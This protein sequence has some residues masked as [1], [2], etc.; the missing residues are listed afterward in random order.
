MANDQTT[1]T[2]APLFTWRSAI[3]ES[4]LPPS[5]RH[6]LLA[7]SLYMNQ[8]GGSAY[9]GAF[10]LSSDTGLHVRTV[11]R[12]LADATK[13][14]YLIVVRRGG[15]VNG[16]RRATEYVAASPLGQRDQWHD[17]TGDTDSPDQWSDIPRPVAPDHPISSL[18]SSQNSSGVA[19]ISDLPKSKPPWLEEG[20]TYDEWMQRAVR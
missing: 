1:A 16:E 11:R 20:I 3:C 5:T 2:L 14:G 17:A 18:N 4:K 6:I 7:L 13:S 10:R 12:A 15:T 9:P 8:R 19:S